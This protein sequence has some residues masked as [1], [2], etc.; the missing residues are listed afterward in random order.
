MNKGTNIGVITL[1]FT[2]TRD[3]ES[4]DEDSYEG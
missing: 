4:L 3:A 1:F 2:E